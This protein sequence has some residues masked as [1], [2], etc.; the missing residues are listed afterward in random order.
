MPNCLEKANI[1]TFADDKTLLYSSNSL[2]VYKKGIRTTYKVKLWQT[3][4]Y[5]CHNQN[6]GSETRVT[7][8]QK[9]VIGRKL[10]K[11][12]NQEKYLKLLKRKNLS[13]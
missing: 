6:L 9:L 2:Q 7:S 5:V 8:V 1:R 13:F 4:I 12:Q 11:V 3:H 10:V